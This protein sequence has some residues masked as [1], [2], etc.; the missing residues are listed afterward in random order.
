MYKLSI[1]QIEYL[2]C[3]INYSWYNNSH[4]LEIKNLF[5]I[6][7]TFFQFNFDISFR[8]YILDPRGRCYK[9][10]FS[11]TN[12][13]NKIYAHK[14]YFQHRNHKSEPAA[15]VSTLV[16]SSVNYNIPNAPNI[17]FFSLY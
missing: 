16:G 10:P 5:F 17:W 14:P 6:R 4:P 15:S 11:S 9:C 3:K 7:N 1:V 12:R 2:L 8:Y 13:E